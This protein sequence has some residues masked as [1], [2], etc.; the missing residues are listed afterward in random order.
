M[1]LMRVGAKGAEKPAML[2]ADGRIR[3]L[4]GIITDIAGETLTPEGLDRLRALDPA[5]LP[6]LPADRIGPCVSGVGKFICVG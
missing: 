6:E 3:D 5:T 2:D 1:K 4:S